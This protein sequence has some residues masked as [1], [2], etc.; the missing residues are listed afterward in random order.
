[1]WCPTQARSPFATQNVFLSSAP[2]ASR[3]RRAGSGSRRLAGTWPRERRSVIPA[4][5]T[6]S[7]VRVWISRSCSRKRSAIPSSRSRAS[8]SRK[9]IGSSDTLPLVITS[10]SPASATSRWWSGE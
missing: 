1:M 6:E 4:R 3:W 7:S 10:V 9:A 5:T 8:S 2:Q